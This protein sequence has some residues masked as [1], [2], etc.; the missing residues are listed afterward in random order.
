MLQTG[1]APFISIA[2]NLQHR[3]VSGDGRMARLAC[4]LEG[5]E[6]RI[7]IS[8]SERWCRELLACRQVIVIRDPPVVQIFESLSHALYSACVL[9]D[10][11]RQQYLLHISRI[12]C[13]R[14]FEVGRQKMVATHLHIE[15]L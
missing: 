2:L 12:V 10:H 11:L 5:L 15:V 8:F 14:M 4:E 7:D 3:S 9:Y 6:V 1:V 13:L